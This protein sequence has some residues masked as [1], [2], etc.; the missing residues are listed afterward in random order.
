MQSS[1]VA[2]GEIAL[3]LFSS[4]FSPLYCCLVEIKK[5]KSLVL[6]LESFSF[7]LGLGL[8]ILFSSAALRTLY[9]TPVI[10]TRQFCNLIATN[11]YLRCRTALE[12]AKELQKLRK[13]PNGVSIEDLATI[14]TKQK[15]M[16][17]EVVY[18]QLS[19]YA[20]CVIITG[21]PKFHGQNLVNMRFICTKISGPRHEIMLCEV[22]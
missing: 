14:K 16:S 18:D 12:E 10:I 22:L 8:D 2:N 6:G 5:L 1:N 19:I 21:T 3:F 11:I 15:E 7:G 17:I 9:Y 13:R 20:R 4:F